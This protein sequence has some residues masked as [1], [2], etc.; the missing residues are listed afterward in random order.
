MYAISGALL[1]LAPSHTL[2]H[3]RSNLTPTADLQVLAR[4]Y[5]SWR[6]SFSVFCL[7]SFSPRGRGQRYLGALSHLR[8]RLH[9][10]VVVGIG[11]V[12]GFY[13]DSYPSPA[14]GTNR[15]IWSTPNFWAFCSRLPR[16]DLAHDLLL[17]IGRP[18]MPALAT[19]LSDYCYLLDCGA[20][21]AVVAGTIRTRMR[22]SGGLP[23]ARDR[24][25]ISSPRAQLEGRQ[26]HGHQRP[27]LP[28]WS[29][30][31]VSAS[32]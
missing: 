23:R 15:P 1:T 7:A 14:H 5:R 10:T 6:S 20:D 25:E 32:P 2:L 24:G 18:G 16:I 11:V 17:G 3:I 19:C 13:L 28:L 4:F 21:R 30:R 26:D 31:R 22:T 12:A 9:W 8:H 27:R 29:G